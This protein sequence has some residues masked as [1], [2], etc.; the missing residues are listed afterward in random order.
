MRHSAFSTLIAPIFSRFFGLTGFTIERMFGSIR[1]MDSGVERLH[2]VIDALAAVDLRYGSV[3]EELLALERARARLDAE[4]A[5]S[6][7]RV[8]PVMRVGRARVRSAAHFRHQHTLRTGR[9]LPPRP[10]RP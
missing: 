9:R 8:R 10:R 3:G 4:V 1:C 6:P 5:A 7:A 2:E